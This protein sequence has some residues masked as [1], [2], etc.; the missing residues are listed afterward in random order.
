[1]FPRHYFAGRLFAPRFFPQSA[2]EASTP[3]P[4]PALQLFR[5]YEAAGVRRAARDVPGEE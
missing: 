4:V 5:A 3:L 1:M 2:G